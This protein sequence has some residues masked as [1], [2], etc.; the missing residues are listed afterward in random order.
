MHV[1]V[2]GAGGFIGQALIP[3]LKEK[4]HEPLAIVKCEEDARLFDGIGVRTAC[5]DLSTEGGCADLFEGCEAVVHCAALARDF[6]LWEDFRRANVEVTSNVLLAALKSGVKRV[7]HISTTAVYGNER[8]HYGTDEESDFGQRVVDP[9][10]RSKIMADQVVLKIAKEQGLPSTIL[11]FGSIWGPR[12]PNVLPF[13]VNGLRN[14]SLRIEGGGDN[15]LSLT[16]IRNAVESI[17]LALEK[18]MAR[19]RIY[20]ITDSTKVTSK[21]FIDDIINILGIKYTLRDIPYPILYS[22][23]YLIEQLYMAGKIRSRP[24]LTRFVARILK[25]HA[26]FDISRAISELGYKPIVLYREGLALSTSY[27]RE[28]YYGSK[29]V[30]YEQK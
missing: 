26:M 9:Y 27:I 30:D 23:A 22:A 17:I 8:N 15:V 25:Y 24:P 6:G 14:K 16:F 18:E 2:T 29:K 21:R 1:A 7:V 13:I 19:G 4:G 11:R 10:T 3:L 28:L 5:H 20:N 12:D